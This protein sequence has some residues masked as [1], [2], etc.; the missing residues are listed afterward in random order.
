MSLRKEISGLTKKKKKRERDRTNKMNH[1]LFSIDLCKTTRMLI[2]NQN[3]SS[4]SILN[5]RVKSIR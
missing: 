3:N 1:E 4:K 2:S 5:Y